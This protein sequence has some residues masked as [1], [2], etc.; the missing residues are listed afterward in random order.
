MRRKVSVVAIC[1]VLALLSGCSPED[2]ESDEDIF[3]SVCCLKP[4]AA[5]EGA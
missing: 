1:C 2:H 4:I 5:E 3:S